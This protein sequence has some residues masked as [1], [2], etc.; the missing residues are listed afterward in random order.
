MSK[1]IC[2]RCLIAEW[3]NQVT[4]DTIRDY[5]SVISPELKVDDRT[6]YA[7][8]EQC[9][10]CDHLKKATCDLC[11]CFVEVR[12]VRKNQ[13][14]PNVNDRRWEREMDDNSY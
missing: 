12:A 10:S 1:K 6:Y 11:G 13:R 8:L 5:V 9:K 3:E 4:A 14:C 2:K 7:R